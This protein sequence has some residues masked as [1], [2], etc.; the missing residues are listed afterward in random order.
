MI[1]DILTVTWTEEV[2]SDILQHID[3]LLTN[4]EAQCIPLTSQAMFYQKEIRY[5]LD[6][7]LEDKE[8]QG[9]NG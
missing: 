5:G 6:E 4:R 9:I 7:F 3:V 1:N 2:E 8:K